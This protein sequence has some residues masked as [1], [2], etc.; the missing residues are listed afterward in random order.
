[1]RLGNM[2]LGSQA[3][4]LATGY[5]TGRWL[6][7]WLIIRWLVGLLAQWLGMWLA[8]CVALRLAISRLGG[9][10]GSMVVWLAGRFG[11]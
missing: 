3:S 2:R 1:M 9:Y 11:G 7:I 6:P 4:P 10:S 5:L 8:G